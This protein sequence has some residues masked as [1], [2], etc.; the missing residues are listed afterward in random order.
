ERNQVR[1]IFFGS[2]LATVPLAYSLYLAVWPT[3]DIG[4]GTG[5][6]PLFGASLCFTA[7][8]AISITRYRLLQLD[9][10][11]SSGMAYFLVSSV[12]AAVYYLLVFTGT[13]VMGSQGIPG[14]PLEQAFWVSG[15]ALVMTIGLDLARSRLRR[16]LDRRYRKDKSQLDRTLQQLGDAIEQLVDPPTLA[17]RLLRAAADLLNVTDGTVYLRQGDPPNFVASGSIGDRAVTG[18]LAHDDPLPLALL[19]HDVL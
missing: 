1:W 13:L 9:Q 16:V 17:R 12:A 5:M 10:L 8:F 19:E 15:S 3:A 7:A 4:G 14:T 6:W 2:V 11:V 18:E